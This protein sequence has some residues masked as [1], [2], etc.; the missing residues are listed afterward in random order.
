MLLLSKTSQ[1]KRFFLSRTSQKL[2]NKFIYNQDLRF[3]Q[4]NYDIIT[5]RVLRNV[6]G[7]RM[8]WEWKKEKLRIEWAKTAK[9]SMEQTK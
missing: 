4:T 9:E 5:G 7:I 6:N 1:K 3:K 8:N 2:D